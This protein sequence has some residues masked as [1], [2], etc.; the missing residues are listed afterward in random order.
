MGSESKLGYGDEGVSRGFESLSIIWG[1]DRERFVG[2]KRSRI[3]YDEEWR[4]VR[5]TNLSCPYIL[6]M[7][8]NGVGRTEKQRRKSKK[9]HQKERVTVFGYEEEPD[10]KKIRPSER[11]N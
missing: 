3:E 11:V 10:R 9:A 8:I 1:L 2:T 7:P 4:N 5:G 6:C